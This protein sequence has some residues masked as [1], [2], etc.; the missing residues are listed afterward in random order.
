MTGL[1]ELWTNGNFGALM[2]STT[3]SIISLSIG[4]IQKTVAEKNNFL[5]LKGKILLALFANISLFSRLLSILLFF[6]PSLGLANLLNHWKFGRMSSKIINSRAV[7][8]DVQNG[9]RIFFDDIWIPT[10]IYTAFTKW[11][12]ESYFKIFVILFLVHYVLVYGLKTLFALNYRCQ[13][14]K[15]ICWC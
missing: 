6:A 4:T 14:Y 1:K 5:S 10:P 9:T 13:N 15:H 11:D 12:L 3:L 8:F 2:I 7:I